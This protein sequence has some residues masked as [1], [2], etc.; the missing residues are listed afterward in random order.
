[1]EVDN[2]KVEVEN[3]AEVTPKPAKR[4]LRNVTVT[5]EEDVA[6]WARM[7]AA[8]RDMSVARLLG[9]LVKQQMSLE[10]DYELA[11]KRAL[12]RPSLL[13]SDGKYLTREEAPDR[14]LLR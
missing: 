8:R 12:A 2:A 14:T 11:M 13:R 5:M 1:M 3:Q 10:D 4:R 9:D 7:E 6:R